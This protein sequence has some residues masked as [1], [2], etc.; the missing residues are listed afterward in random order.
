M[1]TALWLV[2]VSVVTHLGVFTLIQPPLGIGPPV[3]LG[4]GAPTLAYVG[5]EAV[6]DTAQDIGL[7]WITVFHAWRIP[8]ALMFFW[9]A[10]QTL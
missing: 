4:I 10:D 5:S 1:V 2:T 7:W 6:R 8:A 9:Y 3:F